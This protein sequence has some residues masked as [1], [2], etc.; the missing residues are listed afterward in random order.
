MGHEVISLERP[1]CFCEVQHHL[2]D[3]GGRKPIMA[4]MTWHVGEY[5]GRCDKGVRQSRL[6]VSVRRR[7]ELGAAGKQ[8]GAGSLKMTRNGQTSLLAIT[9]HFNVAPRQPR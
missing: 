4:V 8:F 6:S 3:L 9:F 7:V 2:F 1:L 5:R